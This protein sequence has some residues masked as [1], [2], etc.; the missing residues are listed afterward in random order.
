M[1]SHGA[2]SDDLYSSASMYGAMLGEAKDGHMREESKEERQERQRGQHKA[3]PGNSAAADEDEAQPLRKE[4]IYNLAFIQRPTT[5]IVTHGGD[6]GGVGGVDGD[7]GGAIEEE[8]ERWTA[9]ADDSAATGGD[10]GGADVWR[11]D[12]SNQSNDF[13]RCDNDSSSSSSFEKSGGDSSSHAVTDA[14]DASSYA[15]YYLRSTEAAGASFG[16]GGGSGSGGAVTPQSQHPRPVGDSLFKP[17]SEREPPPRGGVVDCTARGAR[18]LVKAVHATSGAATAARALGSAAGSDGRSGGDGDGDAWLSTGLLP[19]LLTITFTKVVHLDSITVEAA[20]V[21]TL[22]I[23]L[24]A[25]TAFGGNSSGR[26]APAQAHSP[27]ALARP[28]VLEFPSGGFGRDSA[29]LTGLGA[30][31]K[32]GKALVCSRLALRADA[33]VLDF[34]ALFRVTVRGT[35]VDLDE[36]W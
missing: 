27:T 4:S 17:I 12:D 8:D 15:Q 32:G 20:G 16:R 19:Q 34:V 22:T 18:S 7:D 31:G 28:L 13:N 33:S 5:A 9:E 10:G 30:K 26:G 2:G 3:V 29:A 21:K 35:P 14:P 23:L 11:A 36:H 1:D 24:G 25:E 6:G